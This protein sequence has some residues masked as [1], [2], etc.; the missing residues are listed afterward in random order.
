MLKNPDYSKTRM[1]KKNTFRLGI[2]AKYIQKDKK[3][4]LEGVGC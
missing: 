2:A 4:T 3:L 1:L